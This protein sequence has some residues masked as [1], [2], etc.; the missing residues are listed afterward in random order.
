MKAFGG[1]LFTIAVF[2]ALFC[3]LLCSFHDVGQ[4]RV[5]GHLAVENRSTAEIAERMRYHG[6]LHVWQDQDGEW[7]FQ[8][9][10]RIC[11]LW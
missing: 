3:F 8:R 7:R 10:G 2:G 9:N 1:I 6:T 4:E 5:Q 11:K